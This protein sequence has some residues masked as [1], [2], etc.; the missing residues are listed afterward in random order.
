MK[1]LR[2]DPGAAEQI[3]IGHEQ[4]GWQISAK[5]F[6]EILDKPIAEVRHVEI[7]QTR[8]KVQQNTANSRAAPFF[9][10][11]QL[12]VANDHRYPTIN[13]DATLSAIYVVRN[14]LDVAVSRAHHSNATIDATISD[15]AKP[16][17]RAA[18]A[19][20]HLYEVLGSWSQHA[21]SWIGLTSRPVHM[22]RYEDMMGNP[23]R[24]LSALARFLR[25]PATDAQIQAAIEKTTSANLTDAE[26]G[27]GTQTPT[28]FEGHQRGWRDVL[29]P[30]QIQEV[31]RTHAP[32]MQRFGY[33]PP[34]CGVT[35]R[36]Q[37]M[38]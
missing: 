25:L 9:L 35:L 24:I 16:G 19:D 8:P 18:T 15:M 3:D 17:F 31:A 12:C 26:Y 38:A 14:P 30:A 4:P 28:S 27:P 32:M 37:E 1:E 36:L 21:G 22:L 13:L 29:S 11:T 10:Q 20:P 34:D 2:G 6:E 23:V 5:D 33:L 7:A